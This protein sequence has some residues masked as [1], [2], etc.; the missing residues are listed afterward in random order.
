MR[1]VQ[2]NKQ[3]PLTSNHWTQ[4]QKYK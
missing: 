3:L 2:Q 1:E 4:K